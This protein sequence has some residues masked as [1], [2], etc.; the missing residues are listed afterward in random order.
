MKNIDRIIIK[1]SAGGL[2]DHLRLSTIPELANSIGIDCYL[3][4]NNNYSNKDIYN[5]VWKD[6]PYIKET[7]D[8]IGE[9]FDLTDFEYRRI[10][11]EQFQDSDKSFMENIE[12]IYGFHATNKSPKVYYKPSNISFLKDKILVDLNSKT[13]FFHYQLDMKTFLPLLESQLKSYN[14]EEIVLLDIPE[15]EN[16]NK[17]ISFY[18]DIPQSNILKSNSLIEAA[19]ILSNT[20]FNILLHSGSSSLCCALGKPSVTLIRNTEYN[21]YKQSYN[22]WLFEPTVYKIFKTMIK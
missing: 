1:T 5:L 21:Y 10:M 11:N 2:G 14:P 3:Y 20:R 12:M 13:H 8:D 16:F 4:K 9:S 7:S 22:N 6:N 18:N 19:D 17:Y 15:I